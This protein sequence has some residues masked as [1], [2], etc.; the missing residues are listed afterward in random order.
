MAWARGHLVEVNRDN[1]WRWAFITGPQIA[2]SNGQMMYPF[3]NR[4]GYSY[5]F[6]DKFRDFSGSDL[7]RNIYLDQWDAEQQRLPGIGGSR[8]KSRRRHRSKRKTQTKRR[9]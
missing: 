4:S 5:E 8:K 9:H 1:V 7:D 2:H 3:W 6:T